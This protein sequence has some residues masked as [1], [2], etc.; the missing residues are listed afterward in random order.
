MPSVLVQKTA[1]AYLY[2]MDPDIRGSG[3]TIRV[4]KYERAKIVKLTQGEICFY[5]ACFVNSHSFLFLF[6]SIYAAPL[7]FNVR[8]GSQ[9]K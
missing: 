3:S 9:T 8:V 7:L 6:F 5:M 4:I 2:D 1:E